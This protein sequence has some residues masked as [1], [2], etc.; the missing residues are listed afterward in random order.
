LLC[1]DR[2]VITGRARC[3]AVLALS[4]SLAASHPDPLASARAL[5]S[6]GQYDAA[7]AA[8]RG[9][10]SSAAAQASSHLI[11]G[12]IRLERY[13]ASHDAQDLE[14]ARADFRAAEPRLLSPQERLELQVGLGILLFDNDRF[15]A[16]AEL[17][18]PLVDASTALGPQSHARALDWWATATERAA[19]AQPSGDRGA[20]YARIVARMEAESRRDPGSAIAGYWLAAALRDAGDLDRAWAAACAA[21]VR[22]SLA[23]DNAAVVALRADLNKL[24]TQALIPDRAARLAA[25]DRHQAAAAMQADWD[26]FTAG[27]S[28]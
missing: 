15:G 22:G 28:R 8:L 21:W 10:P 6:Q 13:R 23:V 26:A 1:Y 18:D 4:G 9:V 25:R 11:A 2:R 27:W 16:S 17:L 12:R 5:Y 24:V 20:A 3:L 19:Q 7:L 14:G